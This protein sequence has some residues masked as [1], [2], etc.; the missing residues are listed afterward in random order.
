MPHKR[1]LTEHVSLRRRI[2]VPRMRRRLLFL[3]GGITI[4]LLAVVMAKLADEAQHLFFMGRG[5]W[6]L[7]PLV[8]TPAGFALITFVTKRYFSGAEGSGIQQVIAARSLAEQED[9]GRLVPIKLAIAKIA[10]LTLG[11]GVGASAG[12]EGP[13]VQVGAATMFTLGRFQPH[14][15]PGLLLAGASAG[16]AAAFNAPLAGIIFG[17]EEMSRSFEVRSSVLVLATVIAA[18]LTSLAVLGDYTYFG[19]SSEGLRWGWQ[20]VAVIVAGVAGGVLGGIFSRMVIA[21]SN[22]LP[23]LPGRLIKRWPVIFAA[24]CGLLVA[25][26]GYVTGGTV[27][28]TGYEQAKAVLAGQNVPELF[29]PL[30]LI[31]TWLSTISGVPGGIFSPSLAVGA[32]LAHNLAPLVPDVPIAAFAILCMAAYLAGVVQAPLTSFVIVEEM[33]ADHALIFPLMIA[34]LLAS[35]VSRMVCPEGIY[36][37]LSKKFTKDKP[38]LD[39]SRN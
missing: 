10:L 6:P 7:M 33:T 23:G 28:G 3:M 38:L 15:Q 20:W 30:K 4:G 5:R 39:R 8:L 25:I 29:G 26:A 37:A 1:T 21:F 16:I 24:A 31:A 13:T 9:R 17:I 35:A 32:G 22:G 11:L 18:G 34:A 2:L 14:R 27:F 19:V 12:R 36:H